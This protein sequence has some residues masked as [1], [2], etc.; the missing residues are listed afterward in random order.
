MDEQLHP[1][2]VECMLALQAARDENARLRTFVKEARIYFHAYN[3][4]GVCAV[5]ETKAAALLARLDA[6]EQVK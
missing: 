5:L 3:D 2:H 1:Q 6:G 4:D